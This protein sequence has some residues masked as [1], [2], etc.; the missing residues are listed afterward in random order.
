M[1]ALIN[2]ARDEADE[3]FW[4][5]AAFAEVRALWESCVSC[6]VPVARR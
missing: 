5:Q 2:E 6:A 3:E 4:G 1:G